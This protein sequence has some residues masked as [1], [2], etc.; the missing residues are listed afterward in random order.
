MGNGMWSHHQ[1]FTLDS[2][3]QWPPSIVVT[4]NNESATVDFKT[5]DSAQNKTTKSAVNTL[6]HTRQTSFGNAMANQANKMATV[7]NPYK[8]GS[9]ASVIA[10]RRGDLAAK[11]RQVSDHP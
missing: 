9:S 3:R 7:E 11:N 5:Q 10:E 2:K 6:A 1:F 8:K 4:Y